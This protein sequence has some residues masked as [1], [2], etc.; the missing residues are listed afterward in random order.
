MR[1][2]GTFLGL[3]VVTSSGLRAGRDHEGIARAALAGGADMVQ[4][5]APELDDAALAPLARRI[6]DLCR[7]RGVPLVVNDRLEVAC[8]AGADGVHLGQDDNPGTARARLGAGP[9]LGISVH[10]AAEA[11]AAE[12]A[13]ADYLGVT[14]FATGTKPEARPAGPDG[15]RALAAATRLPVLAIGGITAANAAEALAAGAAGVAV[16]SAVAA[17]ADP[18]AA[19]RALA[20]VAGRAAHL[21]LGPA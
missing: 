6:A 19:T 18:V 21:G 2:G 13:G 8:A 11:R 1:A 14:L 9:L 3:C 5:R 17:A 7:D 16:V 4:L 15:L 10:S 12:A 20:A